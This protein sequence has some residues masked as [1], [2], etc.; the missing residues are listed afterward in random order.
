M[1]KFFRLASIGFYFLN[2]LLF[3][4]VGL[5]A[6]K[7]TGAGKNQMLAGGAIVLMWGVMFAGLAFIASIFIVRFASLKTI[8]T[9][10]WILLILVVF[11]YGYGYYRLSTRDQHRQENNSKQQT[12]KPVDMV[13][14]IT[15]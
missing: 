12:T 11:I 15:E 9:T 13:I 7:L 8:K 5:Y 10:N 1:S 14:S 6:A 3:F 4:V 2:V